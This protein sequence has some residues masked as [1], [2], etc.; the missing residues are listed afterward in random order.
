MIT[1]KEIPFINW[2][3]NPVGY[4]IYYEKISTGEE[5]ELEYIIRTLDVGVV[6]ST[7][8]SGLEVYARYRIRVAARTIIGAGGKS[9]YVFF[10]KICSKKLWYR[11]YLYIER[12][13]WKKNLFLIKQYKKATIWNN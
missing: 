2:E 13:M 9:A 11:K 4:R 8:L 6:S 10:G 3:G 7:V 12:E 1:W 5:S